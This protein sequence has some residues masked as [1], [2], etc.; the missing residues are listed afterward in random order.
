M[1]FCS[2]AILA[3]DSTQ[4]IRL[5]RLG[6]QPG[7][8]T[9]LSSVLLCSAENLSCKAPSLVDMACKPR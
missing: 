2:D 1:S 6:I 4:H 7:T 8:I 3:E 5:V 9:L